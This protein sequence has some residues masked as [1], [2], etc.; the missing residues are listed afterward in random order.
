MAVRGAYPT[1]LSGS[2]GLRTADQLYQA[3]LMKKAIPCGQEIQ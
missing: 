2:G 1:W 3:D